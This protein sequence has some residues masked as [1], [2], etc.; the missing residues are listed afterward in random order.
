MKF[1]LFL[2][3]L[4]LW[5]FVACQ[6]QI[7]TSDYKLFVT[8]EN[9]PFDSLFL[10]DYTKEDR[11]ILIAGEKTADFTWEFTIPDSIVWDSDRM[12]LRV[13]KYDFISDSARG[14]RFLTD[15]NTIVYNIGVEDK[16]NYIHATYIEQTIFPDQW[17]LIK[18]N[19]EDSI[20]MGNSIYEDF[21]L[22][23]QEDNSDITVRSQ[24]PFFSEFLN[25]NNKDLSYNEYLERYDAF[26][27]KYPDSRFL[28][29]NL[30]SMVNQ[31]K[32]KEDLE[33]IYSNLSGKHKNTIWAK[34]IERFLQGKFENSSLPT[35]DQKEVEKIVEDSSKYNLVLFTASWCRPCIDKIPLLKQIHNDLNENLIMTYI[36]ID[37]E[38]TIDSFQ[39]QMEEKDIP[40]RALLAYQ[41]IE[42]IKT[43]YFVNGVPHEIL[44]FPDGTMSLIDV[45][46]EEQREKLYSLCSK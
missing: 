8:L 13:S 39:K 28:M 17:M 5:I 40:W 35:L 36:S 25:F 45:R 32:S 12:L 2:L 26:S 46:D 37:E 38:K 27:K 10:V 3:L 1:N 15:K 31:Y 23:L 6:K 16:E 20:V 14:V 41:D 42:K 11:P 44:V 9:A 43:K 24:E 7:P 18:I 30:A 19:D 4:S 29:S 34:N 33:K 21:S 22:L